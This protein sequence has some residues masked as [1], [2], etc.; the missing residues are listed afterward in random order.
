MKNGGWVPISK[1]LARFLPKDRPFTRLEAAY[2][3]QLDYDSGRQ[4]T[5]SG[6]ADLWKWSKG[7]V[8]RFFRDIGI[9]IQYPDSTGRKQ[10]QRGLIMIQK[11]DRKP[12]D[13]ELMR[14]IDSRHLEEKTNRKQTDRGL[15]TDRSQDA[16]IDPE[17]D[18]NL[19]NLSRLLF[20]LIQSRDP[21]AKKPDLIKWASHLDKLNR[22]DG[23]SIS[24]IEAVI[25]WCQSDQF[26]QNNVLSTITLRKKFQQLLLKMNGN[27]A[28]SQAKEAAPRCFEL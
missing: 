19:L 27:R 12:T 20:D 28:A 23:R 3:L 15:K 11:T 16:T 25:R 18:P 7:K 2:S 4:V 13:N 5:L 10:N 22:I 17:P 1:A 6:Y 8:I 9:Q 14:L 24:E 21:K 26:W